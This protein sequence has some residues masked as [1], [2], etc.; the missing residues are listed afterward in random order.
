MAIRHLLLTLTCLVVAT[1]LP[2]QAAEPAS[3]TGPV[4]EGYGPVYD[5]VVPD[6]MPA[7]GTEY[8]VLFDVWQGPEDPAQPNPRIER[9]ARFLNMH[10]RADVDPDAMH[11]AIVLHG[12]AGRAVL[13]HAAY[14]KRFGTDNPD[15]ELLELL[16][17]QGTRI[18]ICGQSA[19]YRGYAKAEMIA[20]VRISLSAMT[21]ILGLQEE[22]Y[23]LLP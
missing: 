13:N 16:A 2:A 17:A 3:S 5:D 14:R 4:I 9:L 22:G 8:R 11:L 15:L 12:S 7:E 18:F 19:A 1:H 10:A 23:R 6:W 20:P 21:A